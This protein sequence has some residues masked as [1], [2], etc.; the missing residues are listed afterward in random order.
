[1]FERSYAGGEYNKRRPMFDLSS[2][3]DSPCSVLTEPIAALV[4]DALVRS[5][6]H[7]EADSRKTIELLR[8]YFGKRFRMASG[9]ESIAPVDHNKPRSGCSCGCSGRCSE[10]HGFPQHVFEAL[11]SGSRRLDRVTRRSFERA[12]GVDLRAVRICLSRAA[13]RS[14]KALGASAYVIDDNIVFST[15]EF[16]PG[17][18]RGDWILAHELVHVMQQW[19]GAATRGRCDMAGRRQYERQAN[20]IAGLLVSRQPGKCILFNGAGLLAAPAVLQTVNPIIAK[21]G[22]ICVEVFLDPL[23]GAPCG[24]VDCGFT[25]T[26]GPRATSW[27]AYSCAANKYGAFIINTVCGPVG[28]YFTDQFAN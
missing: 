28:P 3:R 19:R 25:S 2:N 22:S 15:D 23:N 11:E 6:Q 5:E 13:D 12:L 1:M 9:G 4:N 24:L 26:P 7:P 21:C 17:S 8:N 14:T 10:T 20:I 27:C 18:R 16:E